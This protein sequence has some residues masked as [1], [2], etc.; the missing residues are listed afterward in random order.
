M[1]KYLPLM[2]ALVLLTIIALPAQTIAQKQVMPVQ[3]GV[4]TQFNNTEPMRYA[5][6]ATEQQV[7]RVSQ[8]L[9][10]SAPR[11]PI[12]MGTS[13][14]IG[15][16]ANAFTTIGQDRLQI[17]ADPFTNTVAVVHR[18]NDRASGSVG[19]TVYVRFSSD[20]GATW[21][22]T[23]SN[24][25]NSAQPR[26]PQVSLLNPNKSTN[27]AD[28]KVNVLWPQVLTYSGVSSPTWGEVNAMAAGWGNAS[29]LYK[30]FPMPPNWLIP[31][32]IIPNY[33]TKK[34]YTIVRAVEPSNGSAI[35]AWMMLT[36]AD[37]GLTWTPVTLDPP[38]WST[39]VNPNPSG[40]NFYDLCYDV[41]PD[42]MHMIFA[43]I[44]GEQSAPGAGSLFLNENHYIGWVTSSDGG[45]SW[46]TQE[47][48]VHPRDAFQDMGRFPA[49]LN[50]RS[51]LTLELDVA[52]DANND[53]HF[54]VT[55]S[56]DYQFYNPLAEFAGNSQIN[57]RNIDSTYICEITRKAGKWK[58]NIIDGLAS[59][60]Q[61]R[62]PSAP[63]STTVG[64]ENFLH[65]PHWSRSADGNKLYA[66]WIDPDSTWMWTTN[67]QGQI[68]WW[69]EDT[70]HNIWVAGRD[71][72]SNHIN[73]GWSVSQKVTNNNEVDTKYSKSAYHAGANGK[74][75]IIYTE[76]GRG[77]NRDDDPS[78]SDNTMWYVQ[79]VTVDA[80]VDVKDKADLPQHYTLEQNSPNPF[81]TRSGQVTS[82]A[83]SLPVSGH[84]KLR[85]FDL[86]G[87]EVATIFDGFQEAGT[88]KVFFNASNI[89]SGMYLYRLESGS[90][91][92]T[93]KMT[94]L[95]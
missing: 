86:L 93:K 87:K 67:A 15:K 37:N 18:G 73:G 85:V 25:A 16:M 33:T 24:I 47:E 28:V 72:R 42:G 74:L 61:P 32:K 5:L 80:A 59:V 31:G 95:K 92:A 6:P 84:A 7:E 52:L 65:E 79:G 46:T 11:N 49:T 4:G 66:K 78:N 20:G 83:F 13:F 9:K 53:P 94:V 81:S 36:S 82:I 3:P 1:K 38:V 14:E 58:L 69:N 64:Y 90:F 89:P 56:N 12:T 62:Y 21:A 51:T 30:K 88:Q 26:Y 10:K 44:A 70:V 50:N 54:L 8:S 17:A 39:G 71:I 75:H 27:P 68:N 77:E 63:T 34:L 40:T 29:P 45:Q 55:V 57:L 91:V 22:P 23:G 48:R 60:V 41:A 35:D 19:N 76:W 2:T 43:Y